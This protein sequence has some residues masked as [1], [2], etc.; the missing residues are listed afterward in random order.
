M[1]D[2]R[3]SFSCTTKEPGSHKVRTGK[4]CVFQVLFC[5]FQKS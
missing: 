5:S 1:E 2:V 3:A 4:Y